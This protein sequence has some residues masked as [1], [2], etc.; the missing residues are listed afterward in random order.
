M[1]EANVMVVFLISCIV[2]L[3]SASRVR[4]AL[5]V[6]VMVSASVSVTGDITF[7][8]T[9]VAFQACSQLADC[10]RVIMGEIVLSERKLDA[11]TYMAFVGP[12][13]AVILGIATA[14]TWSAMVLPAL[15]KMLPLVLLNSVVAF[16]L[17]VVVA[18]VIKEISAVLAGLTKDVVIV[19]TSCVFFSDTITRVQCAGFAV[20]LAGV[21][22]WLHL[23]ISPASPFAQL[24]ERALCVKKKAL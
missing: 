8:W 11:L 10:M 5:I 17:N 9:G 23:K 3:Q 1:K 2:G 24:L 15:H 19:A 20:T 6:W 7:S 13:S 16:V 21:G 18:K 22:L 14:C 12:T 4:M